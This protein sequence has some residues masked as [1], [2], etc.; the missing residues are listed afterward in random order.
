MTVE[1]VLTELHKLDRHNKLRA[2][3][4]LISDLAAEEAGQLVS[5]GQYEVW[6]PTDAPEAAEILT[7][8]LERDASPHVPAD[9]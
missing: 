3:Q 5:G 1:E 4:V 2:M 9:V 8:L 6:S 7:R